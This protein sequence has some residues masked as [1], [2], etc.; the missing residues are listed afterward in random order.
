MKL[1]YASGFSGGEKRGYRRIIFSNILSSLRTILEA[2]A[3]YGL[4]LETE[5]NK[6]FFLARNFM[7]NGVFAKVDIT[8][9][10]SAIQTLYFS[11]ANSPSTNNFQSST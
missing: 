9:S 3:F 5:V 4:T 6:V 1:L 8:F 2:I 10:Q 11:N 7:L